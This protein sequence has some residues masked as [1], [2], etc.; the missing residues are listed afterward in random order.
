MLVDGQP[1]GSDSRFGGELVGEPLVHV[2]VHDA[3]DYVAARRVERLWV[4]R[5][6]GHT[7]THRQRTT[8][9]TTTHTHDEN[10]TPNEPSHKHLTASVGKG[11][12]AVKKISYA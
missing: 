3:A 8:P 4:K 9:P 12:R 6:T 1:G 11:G 10:S 7:H 5:S 2:V